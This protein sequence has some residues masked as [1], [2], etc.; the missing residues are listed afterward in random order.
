MVCRPTSLLLQ[1]R[2][3]PSSNRSWDISGDQ[4]CPCVSSSRL[5]RSR[6]SAAVVARPGL[7]GSPSSPPE[8]CCFCPWL[9]PSWHCQP[10]CKPSPTSSTY[11]STSLSQ[12]PPIRPRDNVDARRDGHQMCACQSDQTR[13]ITVSLPLS[14]Q[15]CHPPTHCLTNRRSRSGC[16]INTL[17]ALPH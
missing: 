15:V 7:V 2:A 16:I 12:R 9:A 6:C 13:C 1:Q 5:G 4:K 11:K 3:D 8:E 14:Q 10:I 17:Y